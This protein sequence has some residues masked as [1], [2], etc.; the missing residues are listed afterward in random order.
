MKDLLIS[1]TH[2][3]RDPEAFDGAPAARRSAALRRQGAERSGPGLGAGLRDRRGSLFDCDV[4]RASTSTASAEPPPV[5]VFATDLDEA[6]IAT[7]REGFYSDGDI[8][9][10]PQ[11]RL[12]RFFHREAA[13]YRVRRELREMVLF[14]HHNLIKDPPFSHLDLISC[15]NLLIY[16]NRAAQERI[17]ETFHFALRPRRL[18][19]ARAFGVARRRRTSCSC[20]STGPHHFYQSRPD[21]S[22]LV[23]PEPPG[24][25]RAAA[26]AAG[27]PAPA[28]ALR[29]ARR[30]T[31]GCSRS[32]RRPR[33]SS[34]RT[35]TSCTCPPRAPVSCRWRAGEPSRDLLKLVRPELRVDLRTALYQSANAARQRRGQERAGAV[36]GAAGASTSSSAR[37]CA[38]TIRRAASSSS[39]SPITT[40]AEMPDAGCGRWSRRPSRSPSSS[41]RSWRASRRSCGRPIEQYEAQVEEAKASNEEQQATNEELRSSAEEL[42]TSK[43]ELQSVNEELTTVNQELKIKIDELR[44]SNNDFQN[45]INSTDIATIFLDRSL[46]VKLTHAARARH[47]QPAPDRRRPAALGHHQRLRYDGLDER[48][49]TGARRAAGHRS[50]SAGAR[51]PLVSDA[52]PAVPH[53][54]R[55][56]RRRRPDVSGHHRAPRG[57]VE[58]CARA[59]SACGC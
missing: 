29:A 31:T 59:R 47:V 33:W 26:A 49:A 53:R 40:A 21:G 9:D 43:E 24:I 17:V 25:D 28:G 16:L 6:A 8:A 32:T 48:H 7:A 51:R 5:Q 19:A 37:C 15:R 36:E 2:F 44:L 27:R 10:I 46:R 56:H 35:T 45:L 11:E 58:R 57:R 22:R 4:A 20:R 12:D 54:R 38:T 50:R 23:L 18:P 55:S 52:Y 30:C 34:P 3:F 42:E 1:V 39:S 41:K 14:A 13:G